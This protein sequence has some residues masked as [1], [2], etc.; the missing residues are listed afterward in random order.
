MSTMDTDVEQ[1]ADEL[2]ERL[3]LT[4]EEVDALRVLLLGIAVTPSLRPK[5][6]SSDARGRRG[7]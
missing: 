7:A 2:R 4:T 5:R 3:H 1:L 6:A